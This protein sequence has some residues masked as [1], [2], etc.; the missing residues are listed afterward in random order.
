MSL[1]DLMVTG[2][3]IYGFWVAQIKKYTLKNTPQQI[4]LFLCFNIV[5]ALRGSYALIYDNPGR[6]SNNYK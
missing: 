3:I 2:M 6:S 5:L 1:A 4:I